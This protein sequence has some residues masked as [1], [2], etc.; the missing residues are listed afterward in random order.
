MFDVAKAKEF[1]VDYVG[2]RIDWEHRPEP[3]SPLYMQVS[4]GEVILHLTEHYGDA[5]PG[6][7]VRFEV[8]GLK[9]FHNYLTTRSYRYLHPGFEEVPWGWHRVQLLDP[10]GNRLNFEERI[11]R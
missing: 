10:F 5:C 11:G 9:E 7:A 4:L 8:T 2:F 3:T 6:S 1:Y